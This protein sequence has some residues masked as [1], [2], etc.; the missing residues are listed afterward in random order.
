MW[1]PWSA[2][3]FARPSKAGKQN[4]VGWQ[5]HKKLQ[6]LVC[7]YIILIYHIFISYI[8]ISYIY[9]DISFIYIYTHIYW[10]HLNSFNICVREHSK[11]AA[12]FS[13]QQGETWPALG[14]VFVNNICIAMQLPQGQPSAL[15]DLASGRSCWED[16][17]DSDSDDIIKTRALALWCPA[18]KI[19]PGTCRMSLQLS[20]RRRLATSQLSFHSLVWRLWR[21]KETFERCVDSVLI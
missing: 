11:H 7:I 15:Q 4:T 6:H 14:A 8:D 10:Y 3:V 17:A 9:I 12:S 13:A 18:C 5:S 16:R 1:D 2:H 19:K 20:A 21:W